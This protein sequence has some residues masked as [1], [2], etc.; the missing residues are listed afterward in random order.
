LLALSFGAASCAEGMCA[1]QSARYERLR[2][3]AVAGSTRMLS[4]EAGK[5]REKAL[6][7]AILCAEVN[8][9]ASCSKTIPGRLRLSPF[10]YSGIVSK[11]AEYDDE[12]EDEK[13]ASVLWLRCFLPVPGV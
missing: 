5:P 6:L 12:P 9:S 2:L 4:G 10:D 8:H 1:K 7:F 13:L 11:N 3:A